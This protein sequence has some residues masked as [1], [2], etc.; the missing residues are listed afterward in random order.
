MIPK[1]DAAFIAYARFFTD[2]IRANRVPWGIRETQFAPLQVANVEAQAAWLK[3][4]DK[5]TAGN[6]ATIDKDDTFDALRFLITLM[7][8]TLRGAI[9]L[10]TDN[11]LHHLGVTPRRRP[12]REKLV[13]PAVN[14][15]LV[16]NRSGFYK[17]IAV[18]KEL[19]LGGQRT[20]RIRDKRLH[21]FIVVRYCFIP[22]DMLLP[23]NREE[24]DW[25]T[26]QAIGRAQTTIDAT[27]KAGLKLVVQSAFHNT[28][29]TGPWSEPFE[30]I[31]S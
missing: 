3:H 9:D 4:T 1:T 11:D 17:F 23:V 30:I 16:V 24:L 7:H 8:D 20:K 27:G 28:A 22:I 12:A 26:N 15:N 14:P 13:I 25:T 5:Q 29:G 31:V 21:P 2:Q 18:S 19:E 6:A 10:V